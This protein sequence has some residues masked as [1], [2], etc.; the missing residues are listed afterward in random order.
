MK[1]VFGLAIVMIASLLL[2][3]GC[4]KKEETPKEIMQVKN[5][6]TVTISY[7]TTTDEITPEII[8]KDIIKIIKLGQ[9][10]LFNIFDQNLLGGKVWDTVQ[11]KLKGEKFY[12][13]R[14][15]DGNIQEIPVDVLTETNITIVKGQKVNFG[16]IKGIVTQIKDWYVTID[17][18]PDYLDKNI[19]VDITITNIEKFKEEK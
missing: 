4:G 9:E 3:A 7:T 18:N 19:N 12:K 6:D 16:E 15:S 14:F 13:S 17:M 2:L 10:E 5:G 11:V 8:E 1:K